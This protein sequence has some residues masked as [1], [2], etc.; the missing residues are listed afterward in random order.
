MFS[1]DLEGP[2]RLLESSTNSPAKYDLASTQ[3]L[4]K[5]TLLT[6]FNLVPTSL[7]ELTIGFEGPSIKDQVEWPLTFKNYKFGELNIQF[8][9]GDRQ[10]IK[11]EGVLLRPLITLNTAGFEGS[12]GSEVQDFGIVH[13]NNKKTIAIFLSNASIVPGKWKL[14][15]IKI[16][17]KKNLSDFTMTQLEQENKSKTDDPAVFE[18]S[19]TQVP[20]RDGPPSSERAIASVRG[21]VK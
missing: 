12:V 21:R 6:Q 18:F 17:S 8:S 1:V 7:I 9:N 4:L 13:I 5:K 14:N 20:R 15:H 19:V 10:S 11:L 16:N 2:F 3:T